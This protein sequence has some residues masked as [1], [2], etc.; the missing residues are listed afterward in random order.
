MQHLQAK[1]RQF[2]QSKQEFFSVHLQQLTVAKGHG[3]AE[4]AML[5]FHQSSN[6]KRATWSNYL[7][8][9]L[10]PIELHLS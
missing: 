3:S 6:T 4:A 9:I 1:H 2:L 10:T 5:W 7:H 8:T